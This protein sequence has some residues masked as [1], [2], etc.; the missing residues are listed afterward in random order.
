M[1]EI[2]DHTGKSEG[3]RGDEKTKKSERAES[4]ERRGCRLTENV[5]RKEDGIRSAAKPLR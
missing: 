5:G 4:C 1:R 3:I 2:N